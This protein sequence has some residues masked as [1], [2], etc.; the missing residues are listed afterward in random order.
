MSRQFFVNRQD[1]N[2]VT[3][4]VGNQLADVIFHQVQSFDALPH[5]LQKLYR[6]IIW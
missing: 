3:F 6:A 5:I 4:H 1:D 2:G